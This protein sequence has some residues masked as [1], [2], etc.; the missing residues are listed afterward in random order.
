MPHAALVVPSWLP[1][2]AHGGAGSCGGQHRGDSVCEAGAWLLVAPGDLEQALQSS[3]SGECRGGEI[4]FI[5]QQKA[6][7]GLAVA[8]R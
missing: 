3:Q 5:L 7:V 1:C 4:S 2:A 6:A 8:G